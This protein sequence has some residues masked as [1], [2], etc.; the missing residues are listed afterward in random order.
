MFPAKYKYE[1]Y[2]LVPNYKQIV[3]NIV[4]QSYLLYYVAQIPLNNLSNE[5]YQ[6]IY[7]LK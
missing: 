3:Q 7:Q 6:L 2:N 4:F 5:I 1:K